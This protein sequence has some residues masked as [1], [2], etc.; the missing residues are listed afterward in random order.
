MKLRLKKVRASH[1][2]FQKA[3]FIAADSNS[4]IAA[5]SN[6]KDDGAEDDAVW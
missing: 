2:A 1:R 5:D 6:S 4:F 3:K